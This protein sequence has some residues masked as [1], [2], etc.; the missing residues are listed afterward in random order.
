MYLLNTDT[1]IYLLKG[2]AE[3]LE[4]L[5]LHVE[6]VVGASVITLME[7]Y[8][9]AFR[10]QQVAGNLARVRALEKNAKIW[11]LGPDVAQVFGALKARLEADG[12]RLDDFDLAIA[13]LAM[14]EGLTLVTNNTA[15]FGRIDG[16]RLENWAS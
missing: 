8:D 10:S 5:A 2:R 9:G 7:L 12:N 3:V 16:L 6:D 4:K 13:A 11:D 15:H 14:S 1:V